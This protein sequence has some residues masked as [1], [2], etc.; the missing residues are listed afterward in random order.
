MTLTEIQTFIKDHY[1]HDLSFESQEFI[2]CLDC[3]ET[4]VLPEGAG[5]D[6]DE[7]DATFVTI[8]FIK[9]DGNLTS[10]SIE[11][12]EGTVEVSS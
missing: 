12:N 11:L 10:W 4:F 3:S 6:I 9:D 8:D 1:E 5:V 2:E 7:I